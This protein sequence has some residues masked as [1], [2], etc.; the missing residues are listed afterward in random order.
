MAHLFAAM[1]AVFDVFAAFFK[2]G[3]ISFGGPL[4]HL[5]YFQREFVQKRK[6]LDDDTFAQCVALTQLL[7]GPASSQTGMLI[8]WLRA[9][10]GGALLAWIAFTL[11]PQRSWPRSG[12]RC[13]GCTRARD[14]SIGC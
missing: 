9:G 14:G 1:P 6:W 2:L 4:A 8:G 3:C 13:R 12:L 5:G 11:P 7:P 10:P